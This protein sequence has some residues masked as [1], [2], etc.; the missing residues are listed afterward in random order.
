MTRRGI[1]EFIVGTGGAF[2]TGRSA[3]HRPNSQSPPEQHLRHP[4]ADPALVELQLGVRAGGRQDF[5]D[6]GSAT[7]HKSTGGPG[8]DTQA[9]SVPQNLTANAPNPFQ[10][11]LSWNASTD[12]VGV[13]GYEIYRNGA[14]SRRRPERATRTRRPVP[15]RRTATRCGRRRG[16]NRSAFS[17]AAT[18]TTPAPDTQPPTTPTNLVADASSPTQVN[19]SWSA[20]TDNV[21]VTATRSSATALS[22]RPRPERATR[23]PPRAPTPPTATRC[24]RSTRRTTAPLSALR[25]PRRRRARPTRSRR[26]RRPNL[27]ANASSPTQVDLSWTASTDNVAVTAYEIFRNGA[28][29]AT[30]PAPATRTR[31]PAR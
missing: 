18:V 24:G 27:T 23:T 20:S 6:A 16:H 15:P 31:P 8:P 7:C 13:T 25:R 14:C 28:F 22:S 12:N 5:N 21:G 11:N 17:N 2:F 3:V 10:V 19:L 4:E 1:R 9:P 29:L 26:R 30:S